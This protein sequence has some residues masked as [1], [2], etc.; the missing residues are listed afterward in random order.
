MAWE[1]EIHH[2]D[3][4]SSGDATLIIA[5]EVAPLA[6]AA[7]RVRSALIDGG[8]VGQG[9]AL[10]TYITNQLG[11]SPLNV[12][13]ATHYDEDH[14]PGLTHLLLRTVTYNNVRI[15]DQGWPSGGQ[16]DLLR[17][18]LR[19]INGRNDN[20]PVPALAGALARTRVTSAVQADGMAPNLLG[21]AAIGG[22]PAV[23]AA[24]NAGPNWLLTAA[25]PA[26]ILWD[27]V[28]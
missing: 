22:P 24:V 18:Y 12:M 10:H 4:Q 26:E 11:A 20:G 9:A 25:A 5:W 13:I 3:V 23:P 28:P 27:G 19:A 15:Y 16:S 7:A 2:V 8:R 6:G 1:L 14:L 17:R 21:I